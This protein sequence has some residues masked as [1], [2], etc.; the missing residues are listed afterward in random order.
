VGC[1]IFHSEI[2]PSFTTKIHY[3]SAGGFFLALAFMSYFQFTKTKETEI[4]SE[5]RTR[6]KI[7]RTCAIVILITMLMIFSYHEYFGTVLL[8]SSYKPV[9]F[10]EWTALAAFGISWLV[11]G[12]VFLKDRKKEIRH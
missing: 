12:E 5:K 4:S 1:D 3:I 8:I 6:N 7:Y 10:L 9:F 2:Y 11:K